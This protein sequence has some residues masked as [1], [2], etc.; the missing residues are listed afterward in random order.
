VRQIASTT[1]RIKPFDGLLESSLYIRDLERKIS[2]FS[3]VQYY[4]RDFE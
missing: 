3:H 2:L 1:R 4:F